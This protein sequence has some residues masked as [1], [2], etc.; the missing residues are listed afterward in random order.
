MRRRVPEPVSPCRQL[1]K[2]TKAG[3]LFNRSSMLG[4]PGGAFV[5]KT[6]LDIIRQP[7]AQ[8]PLL[9]AVYNFL[10]CNGEGRDNSSFMMPPQKLTSETY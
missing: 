5:L 10:T 9:A 8:N 3:H 6:A 4:Q 2:V 7:L 1:N